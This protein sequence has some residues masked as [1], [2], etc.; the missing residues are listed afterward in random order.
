MAT[1]MIG[2][3]IIPPQSLG[4]AFHHPT[5]VSTLPIKTSQGPGEAHQQAYRPHLITPLARAAE[6]SSVSDKALPAPHP[7]RINFQKTEL[8]RGAL[9]LL[10]SGRSPEAHNFYKSRTPKMV[11]KTYCT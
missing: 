2:M 6:L 9:T 3:R 5:M 1:A 7:A 4:Q 8:M 11:Q 10:Y